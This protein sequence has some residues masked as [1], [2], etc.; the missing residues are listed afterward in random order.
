M[1]ELRH[2]SKRFAGAD[3]DS[4]SDLDLTVAK[5]SSWC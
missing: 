5:A 2:L 3:R 1:I 4:V